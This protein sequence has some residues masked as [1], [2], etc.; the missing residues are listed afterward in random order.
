MHHKR[1]RANSLNFNPEVLQEET[2]ILHHVIRR[3]T[4]NRSFSRIECG[5]HEN[6]FC[7]RVT[8]FDKHDTFARFVAKNFL[9]H[10]SLIETRAGGGIH[11]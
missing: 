9:I 1:G 7:H 5:C 2:N 11:I 6:I 3:S 8:T 4:H 10:L